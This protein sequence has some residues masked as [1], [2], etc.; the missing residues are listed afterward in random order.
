MQRP[1][2]RPAFARRVT[3]ASVDLDQLRSAAAT[4]RTARPLKSKRALAA[5]LRHM[6]AVARGEASV[7]PAVKR[8]SGPR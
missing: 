6:D 3:I 5:L 7:S 4:R 8:G 1:T 2:A